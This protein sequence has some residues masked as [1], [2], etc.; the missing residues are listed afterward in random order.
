[1]RVIKFTRSGQPYLD[2]PP[3]TATNRALNDNWIFVSLDDIEAK[4]GAGTRL[5]FSFMKFTLATNILAAI[6]GITSWALFLNDPAKTT[7]FSWGDFFIS[8]YLRSSDLYWFIPNQ[9]IVAI[10]MLSGPVYYIWERWYFVPRLAPHI[11][12]HNA[13]IPQTHKPDYFFS[14]AA[15]AVG[16][17][18]SAVLFYGLVQAQ[19]Y[20]VGTYESLEVFNLSAATL[21]S[22]PLSFS[23]M[24]V[25][26]IWD[27]VSFKLTCTERNRTWFQFRGS[28]ATKLIVFKVV[29][30]TVLFAMLGTLTSTDVCNIQDSG[31]NLVLSI[32]IDIVLITVLIQTFLPTIIRGLRLCCWQTNGKWPEFDIAQGLLLLMYRQFLIYIAFMVAPAIG[33][34][35]IVALM[36]Q[37]P[38]D[39]LKLLRLTEGTHYIQEQ[40]GIFILIFSGIIALASFFTYPN[41][42]LWILYAPR[43]LPSGFQNCT[44]VGAISRI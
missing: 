6:V 34:L 13:P 24:L 15:T 44:I 2:P 28:Q 25:N 23:F 30:G 9:F 39:K 19:N 11:A 16:I 8:S 1:M 40:P 4:Y 17:S 26:T 10:W 12:S 35:A 20:V 31:I 43:Y 3:P 7:A 38:L 18:L 42:A 22:I 21:M 41:G 33:V 5:Y 32:T 36:V 29:T 14:G 27:F 37:Y